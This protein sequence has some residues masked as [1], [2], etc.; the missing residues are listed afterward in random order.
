MANAAAQLRFLLLLGCASLTIAASPPAVPG[1]ALRTED[2]RVAIIGYRLAL[3]GRAQCPESYPLTGLLLHHLSEYDGQGRAAEIANH[4]LDKGPGVLATVPDSPAAQA[5]L[6]ASDI[7]L[8]VN[9]RPFPDPR[10]LPTDR[11]NRQWRAAIEATEAV[12]EA[13]LRRGPAA[14]GVLRAGQVL[15]IRLDPRPGCPARVR[16]ARSSQANAFA[17]G[18]YVVMTTRLLGA[19]RSDDELAIIIGHELAHNILHHEERIE[20]QAHSGSGGKAARIRAAEE[21]ADRLGLRLAAAAGYDLHAAIPMWRRLYGQFGGG[22]YLV[23]T[24]PGLG[25]REKLIEEVI[26]QVESEKASVP[27]SLPN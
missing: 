4:A 20:Q 16:L 12:L 24:H 2:Q 10:Q 21:E 5:G 3:A 22:L 11:K 13:A 18:S 7:L 9:G 15:T 6:L 23:R 27:R 1:T 14:L 8:D 25:A 17:T 26:T 19:L